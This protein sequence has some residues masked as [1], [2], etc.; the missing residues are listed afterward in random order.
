V[1]SADY[2]QDGHVFALDLGGTSPTIVV[3]AGEQLE[4]VNFTLRLLPTKRSSDGVV[5]TKVADVPPV[6]QSALNLTVRVSAT[7]RKWNESGPCYDRKDQ[8]LTDWFPV[9]GGQWVV[10]PQPHPWVIGEDWDK[11]RIDVHVRGLPGAD[12]EPDYI[13]NSIMLQPRQTNERLRRNIGQNIFMRVWE[14]FRGVKD[15]GG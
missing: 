13:I 9:E 7:I 3:N 11:I 14:S 5:I 6:P 12:P 15:C 2:A 1:V 8:L 4:F 10:R